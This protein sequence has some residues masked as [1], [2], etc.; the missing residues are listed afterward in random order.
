MDVKYVL[1]KTVKELPVTLEEI[2]FKKKIDKL[3]N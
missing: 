3:I 2:K 1:F